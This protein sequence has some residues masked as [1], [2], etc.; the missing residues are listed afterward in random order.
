M[1]GFILLARNVLNDELWLKK[2]AW[3]LKAWI[4]ILF[5]VNYTDTR[6]LKRGQGLFT[7]TQIYTDCNLSAVKGYSGKSLKVSAVYKFI[8]WARSNNLIR[9]EKKRFKTIIT[10]VN[11]DFY[12]EIANYKQSVLSAPESIRLK[13]QQVL[14]SLPAVPTRR[15]IKSV[16][17]KAVTSS[18]KNGY[19][20][21][22][23]P[24][25]TAKVSSK[26]QQMPP[27]EAPIKKKELKK[28]YKEYVFLLDD[29]YDRLISQFGKPVA[30]RLIDDL[31]NYIGSKGVSYKNHYYT[32][33]NWAKRNKLDQISDRT[34]PPAQNRLSDQVS[35][36]TDADQLTTLLEHT[37]PHDYPI[38]KTHILKLHGKK[39]WDDA[40]SNLKRISQE[41]SCKV[42]EF[43][44]KI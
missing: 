19:K 43:L 10:V 22:C 18:D 35:K 2:P 39:I 8:Q 32:L 1:N 26:S 20:S 29:E 3:W 30:D 38:I 16:S 24:S 40:Q 13:A 4:Y 7:R 17:K 25:D 6:V 21:K 34:P 31:N 36:I 28:L 37:H 5:K 27:D 11:Y 15:R 23:T 12:Q 42:D 9:T 33:L 14:D 41:F 44:K